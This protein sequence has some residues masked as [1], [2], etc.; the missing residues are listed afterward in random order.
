MKRVALTLASGLMSLALAGAAAAATAPAARY[1]ILVLPGTPATAA[2]SFRINTST[3]EVD[4]AWGATIQYAAMPDSPALP[5]GDYHLQ[6]PAWVDPT[7]KV[8][9]CLYRIDQASGRVWVATG[10][11]TAP[12]IWNEIAAPK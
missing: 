2:G 7:G 1:E 8:S 6:G 10:G 4:Q 3:G 9:W 12:L 11:G 5:A